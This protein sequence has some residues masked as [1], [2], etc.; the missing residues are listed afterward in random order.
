MNYN[1]NT[2]QNAFQI[3]AKLSVSGEVDLKDFGFYKIDDNIRGLVELFAAEMDCAV[4]NTNERLYLVPVAKASP[5]HVS[6]DYIKK[7]YFASNSPVSDIYM[8]YFAIIVFFGLFYD[9]YETTEP[10]RDFVRF[11][12]WLAAINAHIEQI[13]E[14]DKETLKYYE[15]DMNYNWAT[16]IEKWEDLD[17]INERA[18][19]QGKRTH[20][21]VSFLNSVIEFMTSQHLISDEGNMEYSLTEK[22]KSIVGHYFMEVEYNRGVLELMYGGVKNADDIENTAL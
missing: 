14:M 19:T 12:V 20:S 9:S 5:F 15:N 11:D 10:V 22:A 1:Q 17:E 21:R 8:M 3:Y 2:V 7:T 6:N 4:I 18:K 16:I 13:S